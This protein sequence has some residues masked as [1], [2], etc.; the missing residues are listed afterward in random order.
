M[1]GQRCFTRSSQPRF[2]PAP[3]PAQRASL[4]YQTIQRA[5]IDPARLSAQ[6]VLALQSIMGNQAVARLLKG[7]AQPEQAT[8]P[9]AGGSGALRVSKAG[10]ASEREAERA[11]GQA[12]SSVT[13]EGGPLP[14][15]QRVRAAGGRAGGAL[16]DETAGRLRGRRRV[17]ARC[18]R[19]CAASW[20]QNWARTW[21][22]SK[23]TAM[24][25][26]RS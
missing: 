10:D 20:N 4:S 17:A 9:P 25:A 3:P 13:G 8:R 11:A 12:T 1:S 7:G 19:P 16:D 6:E 22:R 2:V 15:V 14:V 5:R 26:R 21:A 24:P 18:R 23:S